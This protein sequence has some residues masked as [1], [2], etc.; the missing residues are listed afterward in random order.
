MNEENLVSVPNVN[1]YFYNILDEKFIILSKC[2]TF[3]ITYFFFFL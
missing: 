1:N 2:M 3:F